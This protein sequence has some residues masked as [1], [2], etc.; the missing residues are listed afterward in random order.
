MDPTQ[1]TPDDV[2]KGI[3]FGKILWEYWGKIR[4]ALGGNKSQILMTG[5]QGVGKTT[6]FDFMTGMGYQPGYRPPGTSTSKEVGNLKRKD[7]TTGLVVIPGQDSPPRIIA[8]QETI[9]SKSPPDGIIHVVANGFATIRSDSSSD[10]LQTLERQKTLE[11]QQRLLQEREILELRQVCGWI[12]QAHRQHRKPMW[13]LLVIT[14]YDLF[15]T[16]TNLTSDYYPGG[17]GELVKSLD[18]LKTQVGTDNFSWQATKACSWLEPFSIKS[19]TIPSTLTNQQRDTMIEELVKLV[20]S[21]S[22]DRRM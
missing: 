18:E 11:G 21:L 13:L 3:E 9:L 17:R 15:S 22:S 19:A 4:K 7:E 10:F 6:L 14:K 12:R 8:T 2:K 16:A 20:L 1:L 5:M